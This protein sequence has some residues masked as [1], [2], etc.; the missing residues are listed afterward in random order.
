[1][2]G[3]S[4]RSAGGR[5]G[6][7]FT[8]CG[9]IA[10]TTRML[11]PGRI[12]AARLLVSRRR[13]VALGFG[14]G[15]MRWM[16]VTRSA[17]GTFLDCARRA[18]RVPQPLFHQF[19][20]A[21]DLGQ[22]LLVRRSGLPGRSVMGLR[23]RAVTRHARRTF[24]PGRRSGGTL[25]WLALGV[26]LLGPRAVLFGRF[27]TLV[28]R[29]GLGWTV[30][31]VL[32]LVAVDRL[33][34]TLACARSSFSRSLVDH[35]PQGLQFVGDLV[36]A[37]FQ[38][39]EPPFDGRLRRLARRR[40]RWPR[41]VRRTTL[42]GSRPCRIARLDGQPGVWLAGTGGGRAAD[43]RKQTEG[44][45][46]DPPRFSTATGLDEHCHGPPRQFDAW[47]SRPRTCAATSG[48]WKPADGSPS[49]RFRCVAG[50][51]YRGKLKRR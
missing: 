21:P 29:A 18:V 25:G 35:P 41:L 20:Q 13:S 9:S 50:L 40:L 33:A 4:R 7:S 46:R 48:G 38:V 19:S 1:M 5:R 17:G 31:L 28:I 37:P 43:G 42:V 44:R 51:V 34:R 49:A 11:V 16:L 2:G 27:S 47:C 36:E 10:A 6:G 26:R 39:V 14:G 15:V 45:D 8:S 32:E 22:D 12:S 24:R 30:G 3:P 23:R